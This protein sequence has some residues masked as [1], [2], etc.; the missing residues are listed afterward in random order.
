MKVKVNEKMSQEQIILEHLK[1]N[2]D[3]IT[4]F[5]AFSYYH[6]TRLSSRIHDLRTHGHRIETT[7]VTKRK[8]K[9]TM[10][11]A[12]YRLGASA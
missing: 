3:G 10:N 1:Q 11:Y 9:K 2:P 4:T 12:R 6:I 7:T 8:G 5:E